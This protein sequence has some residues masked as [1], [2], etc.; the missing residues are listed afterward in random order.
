MKKCLT[1]LTLVGILTA[2]T[3]CTA[4]SGLTYS[5]RNVKLAGSQP[6]WLVSCDGLIGGGDACRR[7]AEKFCEERGVHD[8]AYPI[9]DA[10]PLG[11]TADGQ[12]NT[13]VMLFQCAAPPVPVAADQPQPVK[14]PAPAPM[15]PPAIIRS[16]SLAGDTSFDTGSSTLR[17]AAISRLDR[18][19]ADAQG[20]TLHVVHIDGYTDSRGSDELNLRLSRE[21]A[22]SVA[23]YLREHGLKAQSF[24]VSGHGKAAPVADNSTAEGRAQNRRVEISS[25][26]Q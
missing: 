14:P 23:Q 10:G 2:I 6:A 18:I 13:R 17:S 26:G 25:S 4:S 19:L 15:T 20:V 12:P 11:R 24:V 5:I 3:G 1:V 16:V 9:Q 7:H 8:R 22:R 21:R